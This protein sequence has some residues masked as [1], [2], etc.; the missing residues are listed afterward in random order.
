MFSNS[1]DSWVI[2]RDKKDY[3]PF[4]SWNGAICKWISAI[5]L[6][7]KLRNQQLKNKKVEILI[8]KPKLTSTHMDAF[9]S[10]LEFLPLMKHD[11]PIKL[12][13]NVQFSRLPIICRTALSTVGIFHFST[14]IQLGLLQLYCI[15]FLKF[16]HF[17]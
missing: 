17:T 4:Q 2:L 8:T 14:K 6:Q 12:S 11:S 3:F 7:Q 9:L 5:K 10:T 16:K 1:D 13:K 15:E